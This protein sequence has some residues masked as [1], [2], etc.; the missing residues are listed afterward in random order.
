MRSDNPAGA[1]VILNSLPK[2]SCGVLRH[3]PAL[4]LNEVLTEIHLL[5]NQLRR[6]GL[7]YL[8]CGT[9]GHSLILQQR[10]SITISL[11]LSNCLL[12]NCLLCGVVITPRAWRS[13]SPTPVG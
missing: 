5:P 6:M 12:S 13:F 1:V 3:E 10:N 9:G 8:L 4:A 2:P 11:L 7:S